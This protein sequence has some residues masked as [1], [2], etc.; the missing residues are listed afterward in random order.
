MGVLYNVSAGEEPALT[1]RQVVRHE[2]V[3]LGEVLEALAMEH[4]LIEPGAQVAVHAIEV[5]TGDDA[6]GEPAITP[7]EAL[8]AR[9]EAAALEAGEIR[10]LDPGSWTATIALGAQALEGEGATPQ[11]A[12]EAAAARLYETLAGQAPDGEVLGR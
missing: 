11:S 6:D 2:P 10:A 4:A 12:L 7:G 1:H 9:C 8:R 3:W 5:P